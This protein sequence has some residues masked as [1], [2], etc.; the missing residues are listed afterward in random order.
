MIR[1]RGVYRDGIFSIVRGNIVAI[2]LASRTSRRLKSCITIQHKLPASYTSL[3]AQRTSS[4]WRT[5]S[6]L[7]LFVA[8]TCQG[9]FSQLTLYYV[10]LLFK[11]ALCPMVVTRHG[12]LERKRRT[13]ELEHNED[14]IHAVRKR[15]G[16]PRLECCYV[17]GCSRPID[18]HMCSTHTG[19]E[20]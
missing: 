2:L 17:G 1:E 11:G 7:S 3:S 6:G 16:A 12:G 14:I 19:S 9:Q 8:I 18:F 10:I 5:S 4:S 13:E 20:M 15:R